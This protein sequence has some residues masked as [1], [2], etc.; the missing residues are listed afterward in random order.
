VVS[1]SL[2]QGAAPGRLQLRSAI[3]LPNVA[4]AEVIEIE[5]D[6]FAQLR[7]LPPRAER[8][9]GCRQIS[10]PD[11]RSRTHGRDAPSV[12]T[13]TSRRA[14]H[15]EEPGSTMSRPPAPGMA[16]R[17]QPTRGESDPST[18]KALMSNSKSSSVSLGHAV[19]DHVE[20]I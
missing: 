19:P 4:V 9:C 3:C 6:R 10:P 1:V 5:A 13:R 14:P 2:I 20:E 15:L 18:R 8:R 17:I 11:P 7:T 16:A 12:E